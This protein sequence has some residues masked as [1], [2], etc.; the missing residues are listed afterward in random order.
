[1]TTAEKRSHSAK[2]KKAKKQHQAEEKERHDKAKLE[3]NKDWNKATPA[4]PNHPYLVEKK[5][6][7]YGI[8]QIGN[9][10]IIPVF[11]NGEITSYQKIAPNFKSFLTG[12]KKQGGYFE[13]KPDDPENKNKLKHDII[14]I[15]EGYSTVASCFESVGYHSVVAFDSGNLKAVAIAI[16]KKYPQS[17]IIMLAD[18]DCWKGGENIGIKKATEA[19]ELIGGLVAIPKFKNTETEPK[20]TDFNDLHCSEGLTILKQQLNLVIQMKANPPKISLFDEN[21]KKKSQSTLLIEI[22]ERV[23][24]VHDNNGDAYAIF[25]EYNGIKTIPLISKD[26]TDILSH[27]FYKLT[28]KG[29]NKNALTDAKATLEAKA[30]YDGKQVEIGLRIH[31]T[32][33]N[34]YIDMGDT[35]H[36]CIKITAQGWE[37]ESKPP[38]YFIKKRGMIELPTPTAKGNIELLAKYINLSKA[39]L[40]LIFGWLLCALAGI[41]PFSFLVL[42]GEQGTGKSTISKVLR[43]LIDP[44]TIPLRSPPKDSSD[45]LVS[46]A[47]NYLVVLDNLSG[48]K[49]DISDCL[50]RLSTGGGIDK[51]RLYTDDEQVLIQLQRPCLING[52]DDI[53][54]RSDLADRSIVV[55]LPYIPNT[56]RKSE[57]NFWREFEQDKPLIFSGLINGII[58]GLKYKDSIHLKEKP[59]MADT[60]EWVTAC[61]RGLN[62][63]GKFLKA[64]NQNQQDQVLLAIEAS[65]VGL[66]ILKLMENNRTFKATPVGLLEKL[67]QISSLTLRHSG[68]WVKSPKGLSNVIR[69]LSPN[70]RKLGIVIKQEKSGK[71]LYE[72]T[73]LEE[74][75]ENNCPNR[76]KKSKNLEKMAD[77]A[78]KADKFQEFPKNDNSEKNNKEEMGEDLL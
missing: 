60:V 28:G 38:I 8:K 66:A 50:C 6:K 65:P 18:N 43:S 64:F 37:Y 32:K 48:I 20:P 55:N 74:L 41:K 69:R 45:L 53:A 36:H 47:S 2:I 73:K 25:D 46:A 51:R 17:K 3:A 11:I 59:R 61:E 70:F 42:Q 19:S 58:S 75:L 26:F 52:I 76:P 71:R 14:L 23:G 9:N 21:G 40:S 30:K 16:K 31:N 10:L 13:I 63:E 57:G 29:A 78:L 72:L 12:G 54:T 7:P 34:I 24:L 39:E 33:N 56:A 22:G 44:S 68:G 49:T 15:G 5:V 4:K 62:M 67:E 1:M 35:K 77:K 27:D